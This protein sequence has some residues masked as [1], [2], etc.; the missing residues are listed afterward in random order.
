MIKQRMLEQRIRDLE[1]AKLMREWIILATARHWVL[2]IY[3]I[4]DHERFM[5]A[6]RMRM[7]PVF[8]RI[9]TKMRKRIFG[10]GKPYEVRERKYVRD[11]LTFAFGNVLRAT[12]RERA[13]GTIMDLLC[14]NYEK[15]VLV[16]KF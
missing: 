14:L 5:I 15:A 12:N 9:R 13:K 3:E 1:R 2:R 16:A 7:F 8:L 4:F 6:H 10:Y 11:S